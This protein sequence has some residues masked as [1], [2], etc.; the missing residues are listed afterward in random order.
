MRPYHSLLLPKLTFG[1]CGAISPQK[2]SL[3]RPNP[4]PFFGCRRGG[5]KY[6]R[7]VVDVVVDCKEEKLCNNYKYCYY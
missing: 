7:V 3:K 5:L 6:N 4:C 1:G 2:S